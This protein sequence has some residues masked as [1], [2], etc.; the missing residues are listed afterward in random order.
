MY[1]NVEKDSVNV[2]VFVTQETGSERVRLVV[3]LSLS[4]EATRRAS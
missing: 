3:G 4:D 1:V 2:E